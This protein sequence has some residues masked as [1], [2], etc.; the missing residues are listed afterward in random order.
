VGRALRKF[1]V[2]AT[3]WNVCVGIDFVMRVAPRARIVPAVPRIIRFGTIG[4]IDKPHAPHP[5]GRLPTTTLRVESIGKPM[6]CNANATNN[7]D[8]YE[9]TVPCNEPWNE[10][11]WRNE[12][13]RVSLGC[14][15]LEI[16]PRR[17]GCC[18]SN[19]KEN[20]EDILEHCVVWKDV[21]A[22]GVGAG[23]WL[24]RRKEPTVFLSHYFSHSSVRLRARRV[25]ARWNKSK[26]LEG[27]DAAFASGKWLY[28]VRSNIGTYRQIQEFSKQQKNETA[29]QFDRWYFQ[30]ENDE[31][32]CEEDETDLNDKGVCEFCT[33]L[34]HE[35][36]VTHRIFF[37]EEEAKARELDEIQKH[38]L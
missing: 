32:Y 29:M 10:T 38:G 31:C 6:E 15:I 12:P 1:R 35:Q 2:V 11:K 23:R 17:C 22:M 27:V 34:E 16:E 18:N 30:M 8:W 19:W 14:I 33:I 25:K 36:G 20:A 28:Y 3:R 26:E 21:V 4:S 13:T 24:Y 37:L 5:R 9:A 7:D